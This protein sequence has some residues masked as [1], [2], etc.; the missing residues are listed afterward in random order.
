MYSNVYAL[1]ATE[2]YSENGRKMVAVSE[3]W[4][5]ELNFGNSER[6]STIIKNKNTDS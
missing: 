6:I 3:L 2:L 1:E 4:Q 5:K